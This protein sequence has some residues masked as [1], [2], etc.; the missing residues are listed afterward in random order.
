MLIKDEAAKIIPVR[1]PKNWAQV[2]MII[3]SMFLP[4]LEKSIKI[5]PRVTAGLKLPPE[6][7]PNKRMQPNRVIPIPKIPNV[8]TD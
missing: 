4:S 6:M 8:K 3:L 1:A 7:F 2:E 5:T